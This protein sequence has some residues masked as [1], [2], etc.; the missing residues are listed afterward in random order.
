MPRHVVA[1]RAPVR[2]IGAFVDLCGRI[3]VSLP[4]LLLRVTVAIPF[5]KSGLTKFD[6]FL[7]VSPGAVWLFANDFQLHILGET[8]AYPFPAAVT[9]LSGL[10]ELILPTLL[11]FGL[12]ARF[13][14]LGLLAM[15][16]II[17]LT[18]PDG[19]QTYHLPWAAML[20][21]ILAMGPGRIAVDAVIARY[22]RVRDHRASGCVATE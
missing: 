21:P 12:G 19:W 9:L 6:G 8:Y 10:G 3:P 4:L 22:F 16:G 2:L 14:S 15:T 1:A 17:Q 20:F 13:A 5:W 18:V 11:V 7:Q